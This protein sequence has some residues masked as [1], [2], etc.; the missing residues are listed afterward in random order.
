[1][2]WVDK[3]EVTLR[4]SVTLCLRVRWGKKTIGEVTA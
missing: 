1:M 4:P 2:W 3:L